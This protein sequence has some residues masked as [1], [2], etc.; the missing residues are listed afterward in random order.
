M[1]DIL[2][3]VIPCKNEGYGIYECL[4]N[5][6]SQTCI[7]GVNVVIAD[8][9]D[10]ESG[11]LLEAKRD[12]EKIIKIKVIKGGYPSKA[13]YE[14]SK[15]AK[16]KYILFLD[17]DVMLKKNNIVSDAVLYLMKSNKELIT[18]SFYTDGGYNWVF[19]FNYLFQKISI[20]LGCPFALGGFQLWDTKAYWKHGGFN[21]DEL[22][23]E[24]YSLSSKV[25]RSDFKLLTLKGVYTSPRRFRNNMFYMTKMIFVSYWNR[26]NPEFFKKHHNYW[27]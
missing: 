10:T 5:L 14:G 13:R 17:A 21:A 6:S 20:L 24:D 27:K 3:V 25:K 4:R 11:Y 1:N 2:T 18:N 19:K 22:F 12:F 15:L 8:N 7:G 26:N 9:S 23:A 16:T